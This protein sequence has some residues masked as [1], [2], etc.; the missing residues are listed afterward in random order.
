MQLPLMGKVSKSTIW[1]IALA[2]VG[3]SGLS[4]A[5]YLAV[6]RATAPLDINALTV[7]VQEKN[8]AVRITESGTVV[9]IQTVN[10]SP[11]T[12]GRIAQLYVEQ[13]DKVKS[14]EVIARM[15]SR[16]IEAQRVQAKANIAQ[17]QARLKELQV[18]NRPEE[19]AQAQATVVQNQA[20]VADAQARLNLAR[21]R[22]TRNQA[23]A[24]EGAISR[25]QLDAVLN[26]ERT[27]RAGLERVQASVREAEQRLQLLRK[28]T[29]P[30][31]IA[32][33]A[34]AVAE[35]KG[36]LQAIEVQQEDTLVR[37]P[38]SGVVTQKYA[39][40]G[41]F[42]T[43]T[44]TASST[45][46][47][48]STSIVAL[49]NGL[50]VLAKVP[51]VDLSQVKFGQPVEIVADAYPDKTFQGQVR[52]I[53]P[54]AV[55]QQ[56]V[57]SFEVRVTIKTGLALLRSRMNVD[58]TFLGKQLNHA[59]VIPTVAVVTQQGQTGVMIPDAKGKA[60][61]RPVTLGS[62]I[63]NQTQILKGVKPGERVF[64]DLPKELE[65]KQ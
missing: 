64:V 20:Q 29:R 18:G 12:S 38:F 25:D 26:E 2:L 60:Q 17:A 15:E 57:T 61:F 46:S 31:Q 51:E 35:A 30:E 3:L 34:A 32:Q 28:G 37:A 19:I 33:A 36:R 22:V 6:L 8:L 41:A 53:A 55:V 40:V 13:G 56:D 7:P 62:S 50:E 1:L 45:S 43:P 42:V 63:G 11:K 49:A 24:S 65:N 48:T 16:D 59:L 9:P 10:L 5:I 23:L 21:E 27:A 52:L 14:G 4:I 44:T 58:A 39:T 54:E 47:A